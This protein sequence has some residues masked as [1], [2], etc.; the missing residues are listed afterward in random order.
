MCTERTNHVLPDAAKW[1]KLINW[2]R[3]SETWNWILK[4][5]SVCSAWLEKSERTRILEWWS[6][7]CVF[8]VSIFAQCKCSLL[9]FLLYTPLRSHVN[10]CGWYSYVSL[11]F[12][13]MQFEYSLYCTFF[14]KWVIT[15]ILMPHLFW[16]KD[17]PSWFG[18]RKT[19]IFTG[20]SSQYMGRL[21][22]I[23]RLYHVITQHC[24]HA[25][26]ICTWVASVRETGFALML[27]TH[28]FLDKY[29]S[30][31]FCQ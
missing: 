27:S 4:W 20:C 19:S 25:T 14:I 30:V 10:Q 21:K 1:F 29:L 5:M 9:V 23:V 6:T 3:S 2:V 24:C 15:L 18:L 17:Y 26:W 16:I 11:G 7:W 8:L 31:D 22:A 13:V 28:T 12:L